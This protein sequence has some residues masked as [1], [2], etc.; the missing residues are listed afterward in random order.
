LSDK[1]T[2]EERLR[3]YKKRIAE[4]AR[5]DGKTREEPEEILEAEPRE[6]STVSRSEVVGPPRNLQS[7]AKQELRSTMRSSAGTGT[8]TS[9]SPNKARVMLRARELALEGALVDVRTRKERLE[10]LYERKVI[11]REEFEKRKRELV[12]EGKELLREK[13]EID[14]KLSK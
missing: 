11:G 9:G 4:M 7:P 5:A 1:S 8:S 6:E 2:P 14:R 13:A 3:E 10:M 12:D